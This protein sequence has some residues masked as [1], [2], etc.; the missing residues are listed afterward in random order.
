[1][2]LRSIRVWGFGVKVLVFV[3]RSVVDG[4][5]HTRA[6]FL[7]CKLSDLKFWSFAS[8]TTESTER[9]CHA[10]SISLTSFSS[11]RTR[12]CF[13]RIK[14]IA[15]W[16]WWWLQWLGL[17]LVVVGRDAEDA[18]PLREPRHLRIPRHCPGLDQASPNPRLSGLRVLVDKGTTL[19]KNGTSH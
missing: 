3:D 5:M 11:S 16:W 19:V 4:K 8:A 9:Q 1:M 12:H 13:I 6:S 10:K 18:G 15:L 7:R 2:T 17:S 14:V